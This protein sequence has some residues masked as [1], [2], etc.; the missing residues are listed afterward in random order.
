MAAS[1]QIHPVKKVVAASDHLAGARLGG[2]R[3]SSLGIATPV[4][5][6]SRL[7]G[8]IESWCARS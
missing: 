8:I 7:P 1:R 3:G 2:N 5:T 4:G 6:A